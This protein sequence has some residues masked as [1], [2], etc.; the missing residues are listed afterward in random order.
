M[1]KESHIVEYIDRNINKQTDVQ[2]EAEKCNLVL[3]YVFQIIGAPIKSYFSL[4]VSNSE[5]KKVTSYFSHS[6]YTIK[7]VNR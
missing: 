6:I 2:T 5:G 1:C 3:T 4:I 7:I